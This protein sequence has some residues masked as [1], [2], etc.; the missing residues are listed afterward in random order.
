MT[1]QQY[2]AYRNRLMKDR[3]DELYKPLIYGS[4]SA[5]ANIVLSQMELD[6][7]M[8]RAGIEKCLKS[9][10]VAGDDHPLYKALKGANRYYPTTNQHLP[11]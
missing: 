10:N 9:S 4:H 6:F 7:A 3:W 1:K 8:S 5:K 11:K 2:N